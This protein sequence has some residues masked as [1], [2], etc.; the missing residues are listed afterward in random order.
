MSLYT[1]IEILLI[2]ILV[3]FA[4][5]ALF[6]IFWILTRWQT[7]IPIGIV[8]LGCLSWYVDGARNAANGLQKAAQDAKAQA[9]AR[10]RYLDDLRQR[11]VNSMSGSYFL[12]DAEQREIYNLPDSFREEAEAMYHRQQA[13]ATPP[14]P[15]QP[16]HYRGAQ[17]LPPAAPT[18]KQDNRGTWY[19]YEQ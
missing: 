3:P 18:P 10:S 13:P 9:Q 6:P 4:L 14:V 15:T 11:Y 8:V 2:I 5:A 12:T 16:P 1:I 17:P 7:W 19:A